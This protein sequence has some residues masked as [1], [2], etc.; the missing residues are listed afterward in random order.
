MKKTNQKVLMV[1]IGLIAVSIL[2]GCAST[3]S[4][5]KGPQFGEPTVFQKVL[6]EVSDRFPLN[7]GGK[8][9]KISFL[10]DFW[11]GKVDGADAFAGICIVEENDAG[12]TITIDLSYAYLDSGVVNPI[13]KQNIA[14]WVEAPEDL[15]LEIVLDYKKDPVSLTVVRS[16]KKVVPE[17]AAAAV[18]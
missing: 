10:G 11:L 17:E 5:P 13:T 14:T 7:I 9:V 12:A 3:P 6:N 8:E 1:I 16:G 18:E 2:I 4:A 15:K